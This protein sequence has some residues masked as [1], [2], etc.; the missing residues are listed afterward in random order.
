MLRDCHQIIMHYAKEFSFCPFGNF[1]PLSALNSAAKLSKLS[2]SIS[3][4]YIRIHVNS[5]IR[6]GQWYR[7]SHKSLR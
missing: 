6:S 1:V 7:V 5:M 3:L 4:A 2:L